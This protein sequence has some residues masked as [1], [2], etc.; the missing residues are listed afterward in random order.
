MAKDGLTLPRFQNWSITYER[1]LTSNMM[2]DVS[3][4]GNHGSRLNHHWQTLG[5]DANM[6]SQRAGAGDA[7]PAVEHQ[8]GSGAR[9]RHSVAI[10]RASTATSRRRSD[11][12]RSTSSS[13]ARSADR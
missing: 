11:S 10:S 9:G 6:N 13:M 1:Q 8:F 4:I 12:I 3:Y 7:R 2:V 5:V